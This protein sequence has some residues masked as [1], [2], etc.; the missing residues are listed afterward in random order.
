MATGTQ[1]RQRRRR[2]RVKRIGCVRTRERYNISDTGG[3]FLL[4]NF[5][6][7]A[8]LLAR[9]ANNTSGITANSAG[10]IEAV[11]HVMQVLRKE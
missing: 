8:L 3:A 7:A 6:F 10:S 4:L 1:C 2:S 9:G 11:V 5:L